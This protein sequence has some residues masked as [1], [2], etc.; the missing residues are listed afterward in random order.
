MKS[1][2]TVPVISILINKSPVEKKVSWLKKKKSSKK[3]RKKKYFK[4]DTT[5]KRN[6]HN[7]RFDF[8]SKHKRKVSHPSSKFYEKKFAYSPK[9]DHFRKSKKAKKDYSALELNFE[10]QK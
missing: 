6:T 4:K 7:K 2:G 1:S 3:S 8:M 9:Y 10:M 5:T